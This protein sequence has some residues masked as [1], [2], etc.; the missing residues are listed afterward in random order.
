MYNYN[1][2]DD[3]TVDDKV[4]CEHLGGT[5]CADGKSPGT[6]VRGEPTKSKF[7]DR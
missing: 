6:L 7:Y 2:M 4:V 5:D 1:G 3:A